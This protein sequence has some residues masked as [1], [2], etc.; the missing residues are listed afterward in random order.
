LDDLRLPRYAVPNN[1]NDPV[2]DANQ[3]LSAFQAVLKND[4]LVTKTHNALNRAYE[5]YK[6]IL[7][8]RYPEN[9]F[10]DF[11][12]KF[13]FLRTSIPTEPQ[14]KF[15]QYYYDFFDDLIQA[16][17]EFRWAGL[18]LLCG[19][20]PSQN[21]FT[22]H[23]ML[24]E[25]PAPS[26]ASLAFYRHH[27]V[28][29]SAMSRCEQQLQAFVQLF[30]RMVE[31]IAQFTNTPILINNDSPDTQIRIT[32]SKTAVPLSDK[33][34]PY[35]YLKDNK[36]DLFNYW[37]VEKTLRLRNKQNLSY[38]A[39]NYPPPI[40]SFVIEPLRYDLDN[41][42]F[43]RI[44]GHLGKPHTTVTK[45]LLSLKDQYRLPIDIIALS[46]TAIV[47]DPLLGNECYFQD[48]QT[49]CDVTRRELLCL[50]EKSI[51]ALYNKNLQNDL[52]AV[53]APVIPALFIKRLMPNFVV[54]EGTLGAMIEAWY[55]AGKDI[56]KFTGIW[57]ILDVTV[58][59]V[60]LLI[61]LA[62]L[63]E[64]NFCTQNRELFHE[65]VLNLKTWH[66]KITS[67]DGNKLNGQQDD[68]ELTKTV[69]LSQLDPIIYTC[70]LEAIAEINAEYQRRITVLTE[71]ATFAGFTKDH[72]GIQHKAG[73]PLGGTF[74]VVYQGATPRL[75]LENSNTPRIDVDS[76]RE[77]ASEVLNFIQN[78]PN[79]ENKQTALA[80]FLANIKKPAE[81]IAENTT[82][83]ETAIDA[84]IA[85]AVTQLEA[86]TVI[87]DFYLPYLCCSDCAPVQF[88]L[89]KIP[90]AVSVTNIAC[91]DRDTQQAAVTVE[92]TGGVPPYFYKLNRALCF[93]PMP[94][95]QILMLNAGQNMLMISDS[96]GAESVP[97]C[98]SV[99]D[100]LMIDDNENY[101]DDKI[102]ETY[103]VQF[104]I[105]GGTAPYTANQAGKIEKVKVGYSYT[106]DPIKSASSIQVTITDS[107]TCTAVSKNFTHTVCI[108]P[109]DNGKAIRCGYLFW[110]PK[111]TTKRRLEKYEAKITKFEF[112]IAD[113]TP[114]DIADN[115][116]NIAASFSDLNKNFERVVAGWFKKINAV[117]ANEFKNTHK[118]DWFKLAYRK[119]DTNKRDALIIE[120]FN[121]ENFNVFT[122]VIE[123]E[124]Q[125]RGILEKRVVVY[126]Q[127]GT[128]IQTSINSGERDFTSNVSV[129]P[130]DCETKNKC[131][132]G[133]NWKPHCEPTNIIV[134]MNNTIGDKND[135]SLNVLSSKPDKIVDY[136]WEIEDT[137]PSLLSGKSANTQ[138]VQPLPVE[139]TLRLTL[140]T[141]EGCAVTQED[142]L[143]SYQPIG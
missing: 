118:N 81:P 84:N 78:L 42:N 131:L 52:R 143:I 17:D 63:L 70:K 29:S 125:Y 74:I 139:K 113:G 57:Q 48:L 43:L 114:L 67:A 56:E 9:P 109:C 68:A 133:E 32:P 69:L 13:G 111:P 93:K 53:V 8:T 35:Y 108:F 119:Q 51:V 107:V 116:L 20:C 85:E 137:A 72:Q 123:M 15:L 103:R 136:L 122:I 41:Y 104:I 135:V 90:P 25:L 97:Q 33:A 14:L 27:F 80:E 16:Y 99:P 66:G 3:I 96:I 92:M 91:T 10:G 89:P 126:N 132:L 6:P 110:L 46:T 38:H 44:E 79:D 130:F 77:Q 140:I 124:F 100:P 36:P 121:C 95:L 88:V 31:M 19:C 75:V 138:I 106:S 102:T 47:D 127:E 50:I 86:G 98:V 134:K 58:Y 26:P 54:N 24:S 18:D 142:T 22:Q 1:N 87:A 120:H 83:D 62:T 76:H 5:V 37:N 55:V 34:I 64:A 49:L 61:K 7:Q 4:D 112:A 117:I 11:I 40:D 59:S 21:L 128:H 2:E 45:T 141:D 12:S 82:N 39:K 101:L 105:L 23:L 60:G 129:R 94:D 30:Q 115:N 73:V 65:Q 28:A 71:K